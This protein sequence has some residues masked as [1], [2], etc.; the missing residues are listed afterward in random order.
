[1]FAAEGQF[2]AGDT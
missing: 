2:T 1:M